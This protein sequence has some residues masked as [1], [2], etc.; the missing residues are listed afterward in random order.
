MAEKTRKTTKAR[1]QEK[2][3]QRQYKEEDVRVEDS[4]HNFFHFSFS[5]YYFYFIFF[6]ISFTGGLMVRSQCD[7]TCNY[8]KLSHQSYDHMSQWNI[9]EGSGRKQYHIAC[10]THVD[11]KDNAWPLEQAN[12]SV[13]IHWGL[14]V[15]F[16]CDPYLISTLRFITCV[17]IG[18]L[19]SGYYNRNRELFERF[20]GLVMQRFGL[21]TSDT[22]LVELLYISVEAGP[23][24]TTVN[25]FQ[26]FVL[27]EVVSK[28][29]I[30]IIL[31]NVFVEITSGQ[32]IDSVIKMMKTVRVYRPMTIYGNMFFSSK[33]TRNC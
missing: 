10:C 6:S 9:I 1:V 22:E 16:S 17:T 12:K 4:R 30:V 2:A 21:Y 32:Y 18:L 15:E 33:I 24:I 11:L 28:N 3:V 31:E 29:M 23:E 8:Q 14:L 5:F 7:I 20:V 25:E 13:E 27:T 19:T 26:C